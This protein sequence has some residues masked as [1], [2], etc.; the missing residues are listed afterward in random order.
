VILSKRSVIQARRKRERRQRRL[1]AISIVVGIAL[2]VSAILILPNFTPLGQIVT[3]PTHAY[4]LADGVV[5]G[6]PNAPVLIQEFSDFQCSYCRIFHESTFAQIIETYVAEG[7][8]RFEFIQYPVIG[9]ESLASANAS[10]CA[11]EQ[12]RFWEYSDILF[13]N[14]N[15]HD[16]G[17]FSARRLEAFAGAIDLDQDDFDS[18]L[19]EHSYNTQVAEQYQTGVN[20]GISSTPSFLINGSLLVGALPYASF[21]EAI[22]NALATAP[23]P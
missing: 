8:A 9:A 14:Q 4:P 20:L 16:T 10:L 7:L 12:N 13:A 23:L 1:I 5:L 19:R 2:V 21:Q 15:G 11:A 3:P 6:N 18:C 17:S 22:E